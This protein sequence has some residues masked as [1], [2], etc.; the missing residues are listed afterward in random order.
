VRWALTSMF[1]QLTIGLVSAHVRPYPRLCG[2]I[3]THFGTQLSIFHGQE[4]R[5][6]EMV[7]KV[8]AEPGGNIFMPTRRTLRLTYHVAVE[9]PM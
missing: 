2:V 7:M 3:V 5:R 1:S 9:K 6:G 4:L 8:A